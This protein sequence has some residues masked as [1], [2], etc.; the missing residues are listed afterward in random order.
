M[1]GEILFLLLGLIMVLCVKVGTPE[2]SFSR[3]IVGLYYTTASIFILL[4]LIGII[5]Q[6]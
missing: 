4:S 3:F 2:D 6:I 5:L 1:I